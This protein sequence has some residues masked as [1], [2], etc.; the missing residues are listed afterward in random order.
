M[1]L[2]ELVVIVVAVLR[3][4]QFDVA[5]A[6][7]YGAPFLCKLHHLLVL[8]ELAC[9]LQSLVVVSESAHHHAVH[10]VEFVDDDIEVAHDEVREVEA[11]KLEEQLVLVERVG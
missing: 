9:I 1:L 2:V 6:D 4:E 5:V 11:R 3:S 7:D 8:V 10:A